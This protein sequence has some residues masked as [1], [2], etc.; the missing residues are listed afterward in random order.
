MKK[1]YFSTLSF[2]TILLIPVVIFAGQPVPWQIDFQESASPVME[3]L[4]GFHTELLIIITI[5]T[6]FV[7][8]LLAYIIIRFNEKANPKPSKTSHNTFLEVVWTVIPVIILI[9]ICIPSL[10]H[11]YYMNEIED[12]DMTLKV[13]GYQWYWGYEYPDHGN[14]YFDSYMIKDED[15][16]PGQLR[17]LE[18]DNRVV[19]PT[20]TNIRIQITAADVLHAW[21]VPALGIKTDAVPGKLNET[22]VRITKPG[23]YYGQ[24]S[25]LCGVYHG[26][27]PIAVEAVPKWK[28]DAWVKKAQKEFAADSIEDNNTLAL[29]N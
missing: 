24:C 25:E 26:F 29:A 11:L 27:M 20:D 5:I 16:K 3:R 13:V 17:L 15:L 2:F 19:L 7:M 21:A 14:F 23:I 8:G 4:Y 1:F 28:F 12:A 10:R 22:W 18:V 6:L 9:A